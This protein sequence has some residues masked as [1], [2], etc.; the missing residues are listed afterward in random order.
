MTTPDMLFDAVPEVSPRQIVSPI[1]DL[2]AQA[3]DVVLGIDGEMDT[4]VPHLG[5]LTPTELAVMCRSLQ[6]CSER[7]ASIIGRLS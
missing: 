5:E 1:Q 6:W 7:I 4:V 3:V 2:V